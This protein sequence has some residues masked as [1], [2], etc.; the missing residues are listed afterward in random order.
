MSSM[1]V[2]RL[3]VLPRPT[4]GSSI[5]CFFFMPRKRSA[6]VLVPTACVVHG[7]EMQSYMFISAV[8][9]HFPSLCVKEVNNSL[10]SQFCDKRP[11]CLLDLC[12]NGAQPAPRYW[13]KHT[14]A[15]PDLLWGQKAQ[16]SR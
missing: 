11:M 7:F 3:A 9:W 8:C 12:P 5:T 14:S 4:L 13:P 2:V 6:G 1:V 15:A 16:T 10:P